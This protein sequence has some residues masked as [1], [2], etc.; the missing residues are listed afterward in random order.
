MTTHSAS[1]NGLPL[2]H[3]TPLDTALARLA[4]S[5]ARL[6]AELSPPVD[7]GAGRLDAQGQ[8]QAGRW[9]QSLGALW[10]RGRRALQAWPVA[11]L[12]AGLL[13]DWWQHHPW[14]NTSEELAEAARHAVLPLVR[15]Y[16]LHA[17]LGAA[18]IGA[19]LVAA[20]AWRWP[21]LRPARPLAP[22]PASHWLAAL[23]AKPAL[24]TALL[25][26]LMLVVKQWSERGM[27]A[28][29]GT[30]STPETPETPPTPPRPPPP[31]VP[32]WPSR[33][34]PSATPEAPG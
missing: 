22:R 23:L 12:A 32:P 11:D 13:Q 1:S 27:P 8:P 28:A 34:P 24:Q 29:S 20:R 2:G 7:A 9:P 33:P 25:S 4:D 26:A 3:M 19:L 5:R 31:P 6:R 18:A 21:A 10:R 15:R 30:P 14:R 16:P 17:L